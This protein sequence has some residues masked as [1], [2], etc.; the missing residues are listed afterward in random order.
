MAA[1]Q[2]ASSMKATASIRNVHNVYKDKLKSL[3]NSHDSSI[4][5]M[6]NQYKQE[7][8]KL[9]SNHSAEV[10]MRDA[11]IEVTVVLC[12]VLSTSYLT[13]TNIYII[14]FHRNWNQ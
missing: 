14:V 12:S 3:A 9:H 10:A 4:K 2:K 8:S 5:L 1:K 11:K 7:Q 13:I 6:H